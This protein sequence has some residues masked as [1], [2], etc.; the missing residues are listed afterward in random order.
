MCC[1]VARLQGTCIE[2]RVSLSDTRARCCSKGCSRKAIKR[3]REKKS[4]AYHQPAPPSRPG[5]QSET[6]QGPGLGE[7]P[8][9]KGCLFTCLCPDPQK[10]QL[11]PSEGLQGPIDQPPNCHRLYSWRRPQPPGAFGGL[12]P[13]GTGQRP[14]RCK[15][16]SY[17]GGLRFGPF[18]ESTPREIQ[19]WDQTSL[20]LKGSS[21]PIHL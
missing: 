5:T 20:R 21:V 18:A 8:P 15:I 1:K 16:P 7:M 11:C 4:H 6:I 2:R 10:T 17:S 19:I 13:R 9:T 12:G 14:P 3:P